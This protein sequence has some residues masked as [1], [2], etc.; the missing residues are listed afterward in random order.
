LPGPLSRISRRGDGEGHIN[1]KKKE[2]KYEK[3]QACFDL[4][5]GPPPTIGHAYPIYQSK[6]EG[7]G[8]AGKLI[9]SHGSHVSKNDG[10]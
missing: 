4:N 3:K 5:T 6:Y 1:A 2:E 9:I 10:E 8:V 7:I